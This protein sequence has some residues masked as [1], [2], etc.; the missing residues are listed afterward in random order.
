M[1]GA[2]EGKGVGQLAAIV[3]G[4]AYAVG[5]VIGFAVTGFSGVTS[6]VGSKFLFLTLNPFHDFVHL[7]IG[8]LLL[9]A[10]LK[11][12]AAQT[13]GVLLGVGGIYVIAAITARSCRRATRTTICTR[14]PERRRSS[15][16]SRPRR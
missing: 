7:G 15:R 9:L 14:S 6:S 13:E 3:L 2:M 11:W 8:A 12:G 1:G 4:A 10:G 5:G 16:R